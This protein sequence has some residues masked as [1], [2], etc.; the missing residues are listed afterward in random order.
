[1]ITI[2][3]FVNGILFNTRIQMRMI[4]VGYFTVMTGLKS[5][6]C[7]HY[8]EVF[9]STGKPKPVQDKSLV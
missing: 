7:S 5:P 2:L 3:I 1:M 9:P 8:R 6:C 4:N